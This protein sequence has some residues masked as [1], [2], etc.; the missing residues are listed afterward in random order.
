MSETTWSR[1]LVFALSVGGGLFG[2]LLFGPAG[3]LAGL[4]LTLYVGLY[5][6]DARAETN[7]RIAALE[8]RVTALRVT[9]RNAGRKGYRR[10]SDDETISK[11]KLYV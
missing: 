7:R 8:A 4:A 3:F 2:F 5:V 9:S 1:V 11:I 10:V 6:R